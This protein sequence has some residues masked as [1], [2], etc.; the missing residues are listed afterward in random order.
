MDFR[1]Y[2]AALL[3]EP[4]DEV[5]VEGILDTF[6][7][8]GHPYAFRGDDIALGQ[9]KRTIASEIGSAFSIACHPYHVVICGS[10]HLGFSA[11]PSEKFGNPFSFEN[12]DIDVAVLLPELFDRWWLELVDPRVLLGKRRSYVADDLLNGFINP[13]SVCDLTEIGRTWWQLFGRFTV[14]NFDR[15][16]GRIYRGPQFM[17]NYH[18]LSVIK[19]REKLRGARA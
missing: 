7:H 6:F 4:F 17:Q 2:R 12:S 14:G 13:Q 11:A 16:R 18:R 3:V 19:G 10:A 1:S 8:S 5:S 9:F 15:I